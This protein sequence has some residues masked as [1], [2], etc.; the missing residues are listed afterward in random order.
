MLIIGLTGNIGSGKTTIATIFKILGIEV[1]NSDQAGHRILNDSTTIPQLV[2]LLGEEILDSNKKPIRSKI[3]AKVFINNDLLEQLNAIIHP[4]VQAD[5]KR[6]T[7]E[8]IDSPFI[9]KESAI[10]FEAGID[11]TCDSTIVV[12]AP[13]TLRIERVLKRD[14]LTEAEIKSRIS[15]QWAE[16]KKIS[17]ASYIIK[18][19]GESFVIPQVVDIYNKIMKESQKKKGALSQ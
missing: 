11:T 5:F 14:H 10:L 13:E 18:N 19:D 16:E 4:L 2:S 8:R 1:Y 9:I 17:L 6:W 15:K 12:T 3:A 7:E